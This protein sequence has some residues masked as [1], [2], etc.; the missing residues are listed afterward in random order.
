M[1]LNSLNAKLQFVVAA[2]WAGLIAIAIL[3]VY[4]NRETMMEAQR[5]DLVHVVDSAV[6]IATRYQKLADSGAM[7]V[8]DAKKAAL[9]QI[10]AIRF[11]TDGYIPIIDSKPNMVLLATNPSLEGKYMGD[12]TD[13]D[14]V[15]HFR[16]IVE[17]AKEPGTGFLTYYWPKPGETESTGKLTYIHYMREWDWFVCAGVYEDAMTAAFHQN[18]LRALG[19]VLVIGLALTVVLQ[20][21]IRSVRS[22]L[23]GEPAYAS[24]ISA[25]IAGGDL[26]ASVKTRPHD[27]SSLIYSMKQMQGQL[28]SMIAKIRAG[29]E[30][31]TGASQEIAT[32]NSDLS[33]RTEEQA[34]SLQETAAS[35]E[36]LTQTVKQNT[37]NA[38][39]ASQLASNASGIA[40]EG[41]EV[42][43]KV[44]DT[45]R[46]I[47]DS[48]GK[49]ADIIGVIDGIAFQ[50]NILALNAAVEA[51]RAGEQGRGFA[52]VASEVRALAQRS[53][54]AAKEIKTL[55]ED[56]AHKVSEGTQL[57]ERA[58]TTMSQIVQAI[59]RV[60]DVMNEIAA[61]SIEQSTGI[62]QVNRAISQ[63]DQVTQ[64]NAA[65]VEQAAAAAM[66][67][68]EQAVALK[69]AA[70][71][72]RLPGVEAV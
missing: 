68:Q 71:T 43:S 41:G 28:A 56:S 31:I 17:V 67:L 8:D 58:G 54:A 18:L 1:R 44:I 63:M 51:A 62:D 49:V 21:I 60:T 11:G 33:Q 64:Q 53:G 13:P 26:T 27:H 50:T 15:K 72:F 42:V 9:E 40:G 66:S 65:L 39:Q 36:Q 37:D 3:W 4:T 55:I 61:A 30:S 10:R 29:A 5:T 70:G 14:G 24:E 12:V 35:M 20:L 59:Q 19:L 23:G 46:S 52:V 45:M 34:A 6:S 25:R 47:A 69:D 7:P 16:R 57:V 2:V 48:S 22:G 38:R 32:G